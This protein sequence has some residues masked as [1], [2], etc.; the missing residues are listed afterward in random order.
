MTVSGYQSIRRLASI[1][2]INRGFGNTKRLKKLFQYLFLDH[3]A[4]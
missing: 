2:E 4:S 3:R 1:L